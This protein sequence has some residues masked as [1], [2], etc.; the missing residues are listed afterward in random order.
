MDRP[1]GAGTAGGQAVRGSLDKVAGLSGD[2]PEVQDGSSDHLKADPTGKGLPQ[3]LGL[4]L[5]PVPASHHR[6]D[7]VVPTGPP[8]LLV[9]MDLAGLSACC[10]QSCVHCPCDGD[11]Q[12]QVAEGPD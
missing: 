3:A 4:T 12:Q 5:S 1:V 8:A 11:I 7:I 10:P 6:A 2:F 9:D